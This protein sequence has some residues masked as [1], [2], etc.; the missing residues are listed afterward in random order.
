MLLDARA[1]RLLELLERLPLYELDERDV[2]PELRETEELLVRCV[3]GRLTV[4]ELRELLVAAREAVGRALVVAAERL[5]T[6]AL[7]ERCTLC[8]P[9]RPP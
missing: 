7:L 2:L 3:A 8:R 9:E 1:G 4:A 5:L 6:A